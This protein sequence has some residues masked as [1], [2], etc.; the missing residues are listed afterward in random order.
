MQS[1]PPRAASFGLVK[2]L[3]R[4]LREPRLHPEDHDLVKPHWAASSSDSVVRP[5]FDR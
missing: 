1:N 2:S 3:K 5:G 4:L